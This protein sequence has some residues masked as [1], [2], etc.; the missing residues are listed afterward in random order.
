MLKSPLWSNGSSSTAV[1]A[2]AGTATGGAATVPG[3]VCGGVGD[4]GGG[5]P[6]EPGGLG[7]GGGGV[8]AEPGG[9]GDGGGG[10]V[11]GCGDA[12]G[13]GSGDAPGDGCGALSEHSTRRSSMAM[14]S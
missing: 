4:G 2:A 8:L 10:R 14:S 5:V 7:D 3:R 12:P 13:D 1:P 9:V 11:T 6:P